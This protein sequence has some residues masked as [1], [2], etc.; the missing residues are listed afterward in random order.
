MNFPVMT[1]NL[2]KKFQLS[3]SNLKDILRRTQP[4]EVVAVDKV[5]LKIEDGEIFG[6]L[7]PNGSGKTTFLKLLSTMLHPSSG[8]ARIYGHD[9]IQDDLKVRR[10]VGLVTGEE[11]SH[12]WRLTGRQNLQFFASLFML[13]KKEINQRVGEVIALLDLT[14][15]ADLRVDKYSAGMKQKL[16]IAR[17]LLGKPKLLFLDEPTRGLDPIA[18]QSLLDLISQRIVGYS[19]NTVILTT[20]ILSEVE[21][22]CNRIA[23]LKRGQIVAQ[24][25]LYE[26]KKAAQIY[27]RYSIYLHNY[28]IEHLSEFEKIKGVISCSNKIQENSN[29]SLEF[30]LAKDSFALS[31]VLKFIIHKNADILKCTSEE[32]RFDD[33]F[34]MIIQGRQANSI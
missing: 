23:I 19:G 11:R 13:G 20:H 30:L 31:D 1:H 22:L 16:A 9:V 21:K 15:V 8:I 10:C 18:A 29:L 7:G 32:Q 3:P 6:L 5:T 33:V 25:S 28:P 2:T 34:Q 14:E 4:R 27:D 26:L 17:G 12:Y 24:G